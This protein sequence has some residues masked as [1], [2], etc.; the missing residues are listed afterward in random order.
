MSLT[1][2]L[3]VSVFV[4]VPSA[5]PGGLSAEL[6]DRSTAVISW[7]HVPEDQ[8]NGYLLGY[9]VL[10][11]SQNDHRLSQ[12]ETGTAVTLVGL[13]QNSTYTCTVC[14]FTAVGCGPSS[15]TYISTYEDCR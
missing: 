5:S 8:Q 2:L 11:T 9:S 1:T 15:I 4:S 3:C 7:S 10:C 13:V 6:I 12:D 14:A